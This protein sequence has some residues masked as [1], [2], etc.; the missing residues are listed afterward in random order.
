MEE[1]EQFARSFLNPIHYVQTPKIRD[2]SN[3][4]EVSRDGNRWMEIC[5]KIQ[6]NAKLINL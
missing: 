5:P 3:V 2:P 1:N 4:V 6:F